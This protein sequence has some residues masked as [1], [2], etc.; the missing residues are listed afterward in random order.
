LTDALDVDRPLSDY[1][2]HHR[3][4]HDGGYL[5]ALVAACREGCRGLPG[6]EALSWNGIVVP[7][8]TPAPI[9]ARRRRPDGQHPDRIVVTSWGV[10]T[11]PTGG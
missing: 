3:A 7:A 10:S 5:A 2:L 1:Y 4:R 9:V 6:Y 11:P 8:S